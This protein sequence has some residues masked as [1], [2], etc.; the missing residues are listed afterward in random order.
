MLWRCAQA[1]SAAAGDQPWLAL[2]GGTALRHLTWLRRAS[3]DLDFV[4]AG[5]GGQVGEWVR[6]VLERTEG[7]TPNTIIVRAAKGLR[8]ELSYASSVTQTTQVLKVDKLDAARRNVH[9][10]ADAITY[11]GVRTL[12]PKKVAELK[13]E[14][15]VG[16]QPRRRA[17][18]IYDSTH[19]MRRYDCA[20]T[21]EQ[22]TTLGRIADSLFER[23]KQWLELFEDDE[24]LSPNQF[25]KVREAFTKTAS[26]RKR[27]AEHGEEFQP[28][29]ERTPEST[30]IV[31][32]AQIR[33]IDNR[34]TH[35]GVTIGVA[36]EPEQAAAMLLDAGIAAP[37]QR[38]ALIA[39]IQQRMKNA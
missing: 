2:V 23:E 5:P 24:V 33:L 28:V 14:T 36:H 8:T 7:V 1:V 25:P 9:L 38:S 19:L 26:W 37:E 6:R 29:E 35:E 32:A 15:L 3:L 34:P 13:L 16:T 17:R 18:D 27:L 21:R 12:R 31:D 10:A 39:T 4:V 11:E 20:L 30:V 22:L